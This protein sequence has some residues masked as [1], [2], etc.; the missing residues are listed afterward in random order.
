MLDIVEIEH[1]VVAHFKGEV[2]FLKLL[3]CRCVSGLFRINGFDLV[4]D[5]GA[6]YYNLTR[7][8]N[9]VKIVKNAFYFI[10]RC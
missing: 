10:M 4:A 6:V 9:S 2:E 8:A 3:S 7:C 5:G 1:H